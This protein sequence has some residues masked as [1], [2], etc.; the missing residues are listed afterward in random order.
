MKNLKITKNT[1]LFAD[2]VYLQPVETKDGK[3]VWGVVG[4]SIDCGIWQDGDEIMAKFAVKTDS[5]NGLLDFCIDGDDEYEEF[6]D[7]LA[8]KGLTELEK[9]LEVE[10]KQWKID[11]IKDHIKA[12]LY[13][14]NQI[15]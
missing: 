6:Y 4:E 13:D 9:M 8:T 10:T 5:V 14:N 11:L 1:E 15:R 3:W 2:G 12:D 7:E